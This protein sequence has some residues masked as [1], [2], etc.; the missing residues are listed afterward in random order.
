[1]RKVARILLLVMLAVLIVFPSGCGPKSAGGEGEYIINASQVKDLAGK[2]GVVIVD[3]QKPEVYAKSHIK[4]AVNIPLSDIVTNQ[5]YSNMLAPKSAI[6]EVLGKSGISNDTT[7]VIYDDANNMDSARFWWTLM[8][9]GHKDIKVVSG[10][11]KAL[12]AEK[13]D[14]T[15][16]AASVKQVKY[17]AKD[18]NTDMLAT[19]D[20][21]KALVNEPKKDTILL[22]TRSKQ[23]FEEGTIPGSLLIDYITNNYKDG[24]YKKAQ[25]IKLMYHDN[26]ITYDKTVVMYCKTSI[27]GAQTYLALYNAGYRKLKLYDGAWVEWSANKSNPVKT[28]EN[29][30]KKIESNSKDNS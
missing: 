17:T 5:P 22:D 25:D 13:L 29:T 2:S 20:D 26:N 27:R 7:I 18:K 12:K 8:I 6:E 15:A 24:T 9:Y 23:E 21:V 3:M 28:P 11:V 30:D 16:D 14:M 1:M 4:G 19:I 10:G